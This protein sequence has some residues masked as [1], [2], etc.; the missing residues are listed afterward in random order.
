MWFAGSRLAAVEPPRPRRARAVLPLL[1]GIFATLLVGCG[2]TP[3]SADKPIDQELYQ[4]ILATLRQEEF[5]KMASHFRT[6]AEIDRYLGQKRAAV[7]HV[8][9]AEE[10]GKL[11]DDFRPA[12][13]SVC[14]G[15]T[16]VYDPKDKRLVEIGAGLAESLGSK[17]EPLL[18]QALVKIPQKTEPPYLARQVYEFGYVPLTDRRIAIAVEKFVLPKHTL[19]GM[20]YRI[21]PAT[22]GKE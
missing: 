22:G 10:D 2:R 4:Q 13:T 3:E 5:I 14:N 11:Y 15:F 16:L 17:V 18:D 21:E 6:K 7:Y 19:Y 8:A 20:L 9:T 1:F 12:D